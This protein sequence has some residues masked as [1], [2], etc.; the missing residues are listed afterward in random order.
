MEY[1]GI[2][3]CKHCCKHGLNRGI[4][5][6]FTGV[7]GLLI[8]GLFQ[9]EGEQAGCKQKQRVR[10]VLVGRSSLAVYLQMQIRE[11][12]QPSRISP[13]LPFPHGQ[14]SPASTIRLLRRTLQ[15][16]VCHHLSSQVSYQMWKHLWCQ[17]LSLTNRECTSSFSAL[18]FCNSWLNLSGFWL[19][20]S[21]QLG[22]EH[23]QEGKKYLCVPGIMLL[24]HH[25]SYHCAQQFRLIHQ[26]RWP[27]SEMEGL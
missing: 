12:C 23:S 22:Y 13:R 18:F 26:Q 25:L 10:V 5:I 7:L 9:R 3:C 24:Y 8:E 2:L 21:I 11:Q 6:V 19:C 20:P 4:N 15:Q 17:S 27:C 1:L 16:T 14:M